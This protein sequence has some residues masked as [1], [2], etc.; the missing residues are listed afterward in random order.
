MEL[1]DFAERI[2]FG[3]DLD[4]KLL[5]PETMTDFMPR[6]IPHVPA[7]PHRPDAL[8]LQGDGPRHKVPFPGLHQLESAKTRGHVLH[9]FANHELLAL[10]LMALMLLRFPEAPAAFRK[11]IYHTMV[12]EQGHLRMYKERMELAGVEFG[13]IPV[14]A[15]FWRVLK[16]MQS[17]LDFVTG[18]SM[19]FEQ[20]NLDYAGYY[21]RAFRRI[22]DI[23]TADVLDIVYE[24]EIGHVHHGVVWFDRWRPPDEPRFRAFEVLLPEG[25]S[26]I[27]AK[28]HDFDIEARQ[29]AGLDADFIH[30]L[31]LYRASK[32][33]PPHVL[34]FNPS[35]E[36]ESRF[37][38]EG[39]LP[40]V[41]ERT[42]QDLELLMGQLAA[43]E[44]IL[45]VEHAVSDETRAYLDRIGLP[46]PAIHRY[47]S[48]DAIEE[49]VDAR[50]VGRLVP[51]GVSDRAHQRMKGLADRLTDQARAAFEQWG[52]GIRIWSK[53]ELH[54]VR[55][56][57]IQT[58][59]AHSDP[60]VA[61]RI[62]S[63]DDMGHVL[64]DVAA[65]EALLAQRDVSAWIFKAPRGASGRAAIRVFTHSLSENQRRWLE[66]VL[67]VDGAVVA[68]PW[69]TRVLDL[70]WQMD[71]G[72]DQTT[73]YGSQRFLTDARGQYLGAV[74]HRAIDGL[75][76]DVV[77]WIHDDGRNARW[78]RTTHQRTA[79][80]VANYLHAQGYR[81]PVGLDA[82]VYREHGA[83]YFQPVVEVN[84][85]WTMGRVAFEI[86]KRISRRRSAAMLIV[87]IDS[88]E[89]AHQ[90]IARARAW[91]TS[92]HPV[93]HVGSGAA[94]TIDGGI[95]W[96]TDSARAVAHVPIVLVAESWKDLQQMAS[97]F[98][99][100]ALEALQ[101]LRPLV[102]HP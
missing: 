28:G 83:L 31:Q 66:R 99:P 38:A 81:G 82:M 32:G 62:A 65:V 17:P 77:R 42:T 27:R 50:H 59:R 96:L 46:L 20:A 57:G 14:N 16:D 91:A 54:D 98:A 23:E 74:L 52:K 39:Q 101:P 36:Y 69:R 53:A 87:P 7:Y 95:V 56:E 25:L 33:R 64:Q 92:N 18:M 79:D 97:D 37:G 29:K 76:T 24:E 72:E 11:G 48:S 22:G 8:R 71:I 58:V 80:H 34:W 100:F 90:S 84:T 94:R 30:R 43:E 75:S 1:S 73:H 3:R 9:F 70:S 86:E 102:P 41:F 40:R 78:M 35:V 5:S 10:E 93:V 51:W 67:R 19:T 26:P 49:V 55:V 85:R 6:S 45:L 63:P 68:E 44:D 61:E 13:E 21:A 88:I 47:T 12:E 89:Q 15:F 60:R 2:L 4:E